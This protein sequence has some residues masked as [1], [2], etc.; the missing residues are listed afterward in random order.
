MTRFVV[1]IHGQYYLYLAT[2]IKG[3]LWVPREEVP[4]FARVKKVGSYEYLQIVENN[5]KN[6]SPCSAS[7]PRWE[8]WTNYG[9]R[10]K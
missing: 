6:R 10:V 2:L 5:R 3:I 9:P 4:M 8:G 7:S 1:Q